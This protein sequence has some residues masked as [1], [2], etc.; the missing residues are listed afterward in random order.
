MTFKNSVRIGFFCIFLCFSISGCKS[1]VDKYAI[2]TCKAVET[3]IARCSQL[4]ANDISEKNAKTLS[5]VKE[6]DL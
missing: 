3:N 5:F 1:T 2:S 4:I 6:G